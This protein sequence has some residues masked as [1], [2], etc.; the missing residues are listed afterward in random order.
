MTYIKT[1]AYNNVKALSTTNS[2]SQTVSSTIY[3]RLTVNGSEIT[4]APSS[5]ADKV[6]YEI[7]FYCEKM[8]GIAFSCLE[9]EHYTGGSWSEI[10]AKYRK[11]FG[12][13]GSGSQ[14]NRWNIHYRFIVPAWSGERQLRLRMFTDNSASTCTLHAMTHWD[15]SSATEYSNTDLLVY[16]I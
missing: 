4:Y 16:S 10:N 6:C 7:R 14:S 13:S 1:L 8:S 5:G 3:T 2:A 11:N 12:N 15:G 9:L